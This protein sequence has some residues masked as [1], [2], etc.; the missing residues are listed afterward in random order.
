MLSSDAS[1]HKT[2]RTMSL[3]EYTSAKYGL[4]IKVRNEAIK[5]VDI[6]AVLQMMFGVSNA[7]SIR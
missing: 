6:E 4:L 3:S 5:L 2:I 1:P 7:H